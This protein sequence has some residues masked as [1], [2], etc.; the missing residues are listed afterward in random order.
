MVFL[1]NT[2]L[3]AIW[4]SSFLHFQIANFLKMQFSNGLFYAIW[5]KIALFVYEIAISNAPLET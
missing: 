4:K 2:S 5:F 3:L 1:K